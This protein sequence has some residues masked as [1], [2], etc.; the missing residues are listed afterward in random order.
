MHTALP[1][2]STTELNALILSTGKA[3]NKAYASNFGYFAKGQTVRRV[4]RGRA[5]GGRP[6]MFTAAV[7]FII[8][9]SD[10]QMR[11]IDK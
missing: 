3:G 7:I 2:V 1:I 6:Q 8:F 10:D 5:P 4:F 9:F 11:R